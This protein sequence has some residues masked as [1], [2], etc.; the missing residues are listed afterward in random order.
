MLVAL[1][2][3]QGAGKTTILSKLK[4]LGF[5]VV[6]RKTSR[7]ILDE[8]GVPLDEI[9]RTPELTIKF[10]E[11]IIRRKYADD[12][13]QHD[14]SPDE[15][16]FTERTFADLFAY[17]MAAIG[18]QNSY[19]SW[20]NDYYEQCMLYQQCYD[21]V[22]YLKAGHF[23]VQADSVRSV[24]HHFSR[25]MDLVMKEYTIQMSGPTVE[26]IDTPILEERVKIIL[27]RTLTAAGWTVDEIR[28]FVT[29]KLNSIELN[30]NK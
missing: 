19:S 27:Y 5:K 7:S 22:F 9:N 14:Q 10:Q 29:S 3:S 26:I 17:T 30:I 25:M 13:S 11:E 18:S 23:R 1:S 15:I 12:I 8:W 4:E 24:N 28:H 16:V 20:I 2:S 6:D 21:K